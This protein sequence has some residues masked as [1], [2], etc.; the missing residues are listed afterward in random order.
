MDRISFTTHCSHGFFPKP[1]V[2]TPIPITVSL[3]LPLVLGSI[4]QEDAL[5]KSHAAHSW[6]FIYP[7]WKSH[8][9]LETFGTRLLQNC[10]Y[11]SF[12]FEA[13]NLPSQTICKLQQLRKHML[14]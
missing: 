12:I 4:L 14:V 6:G 1:S 9:S 2:E 7:P 5:S 13:L 11:S 3:P 8:G 10:S